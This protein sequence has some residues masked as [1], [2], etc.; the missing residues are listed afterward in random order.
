ML[1]VYSN[2]SQ[3]LVKNYQNS[4]VG[5][6]FNICSRNTVWAS[7]ICRGKTVNHIGSRSYIKQGKQ[8]HSQFTPAFNGKI[9]CLPLPS[10]IFT[11]IS[12]S[13]RWWELLLGLCI[14]QRIRLRS[15]IQYWCCV[16]V[17]IMAIASLLLW[18]E[19]S[20]CLAS[21]SFVT[22]CGDHS[23]MHHKC[24]LIGSWKQVG[25]TWPYRSPVCLKL[26]QEL[27]SSWE[28]SEWIKEQSLKDMRLKLM[29][30]ENLLEA[31]EGIIIK[32]HA[33]NWNDLTN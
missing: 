14:Y 12:I 32:I 17:D 19:I 21:L 16:I 29:Y 25:G 33:I 26:R 7:L 11:I 6:N 2:H 1:S 30:V 5:I 15:L 28:L 31:F 13:T 8:I 18:Y 23:T 20:S 9:R 3:F 22:V 27:H 10:I 24:L 4:K